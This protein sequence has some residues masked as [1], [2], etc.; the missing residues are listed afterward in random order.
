MRIPM[1]VVVG[2][3]MFSQ[4]DQCAEDISF[5]GA[6]HEV[7]SGPVPV[8]K[9]ISQYHYSQDCLHILESSQLHCN[10]QPG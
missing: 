5:C 9:C 8:H 1:L 3:I 6:I 2:P 7:A 4:L 10:W